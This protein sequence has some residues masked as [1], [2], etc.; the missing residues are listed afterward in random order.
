MN[1]ACSVDPMPSSFHVCTE[2]VQKLSTYCKNVAS[3]QMLFLKPQYFWTAWQFSEQHACFI[4]ASP[5]I[6]VYFLQ[7]KSFFLNGVTAILQNNFAN[8]LFAKMSFQNCCLIAFVHY[9]SNF[10]SITFPT[11]GFNSMYALQMIAGNEILLSCRTQTA[12]N[13]TTEET[14]LAASSQPTSRPWPWVS[15][16]ADWPW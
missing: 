4:F 5:F 7:L 14:D 3:F 13:A 1:E 6:H 16:H 8:C 15:G 12:E 2:F 10:C 11:L 9:I